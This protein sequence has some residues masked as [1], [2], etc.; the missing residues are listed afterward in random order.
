MKEG[1]VERQGRSQEVLPFIARLAQN[2][3][4]NGAPIASPSSQSLVDLQTR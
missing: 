1:E 2:H 3:A 4:N